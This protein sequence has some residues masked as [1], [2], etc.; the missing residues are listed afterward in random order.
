M[1][2]FV[3]VCIQL[4]LSEAVEGTFKIFRKCAGSDDVVRAYVTPESLHRTLKQ[5]GV[6][7]SKHYVAC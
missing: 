6:S 1:L 5:M 3:C 7:Q 4:R 2:T